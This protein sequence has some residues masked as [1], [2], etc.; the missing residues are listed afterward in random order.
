VLYL[1]SAWIHSHPET[2]KE[3]I[4]M[5]AGFLL[6]TA[7][8][9]AVLCLGSA[10]NAMAQSVTGG[11]TFTNID[12]PPPVTIEVSARSGP[13][14]ILRIGQGSTRIIADVVDLC[15]EDKEAI[16]VG[17]VEHTTVEDLLPFI[18]VFVTDNGRSGDTVLITSLDQL[19]PCNTACIV[20]PGIC[21]RPV[22][23]QTLTDGDIRVTP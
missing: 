17:Q 21:D 6:V 18:Y 12:S 5:K 10:S 11:G 9:L 7:L 16:V 20:V 8:V 2:T 1:P 15:V 4:T 19:V 13:A 14:G 23:L 22:D 3:T